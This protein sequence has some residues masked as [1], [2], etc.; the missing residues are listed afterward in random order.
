MR[1]CKPTKRQ[2]LPFLLL[3]PMGTFAQQ[4]F[5]DLSDG[6]TLSFPLEQIRSKQV[7]ADQL[8]LDLWDGSSL[9][10][11]LSDIR[12][13]RFAD[14]S[15][16]VASQAGPAGELRVYPNPSSSGVTVVLPTGGDW[17]LEVLDPR[18]SVVHRQR[19]VAN[20]ADGHTFHWAGT[21]GQGRDVA[22]GAYMYRAISA[23]HSLTSAVIIER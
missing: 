10:W 17:I 3:V 20:K 6:S 21:D 1:K 4:V 16:S 7:D 13:Y 22:A 11:A 8:Q 23:V 15:T 2:L 14:I 9:S 19:I 5:M 12:R 18:G